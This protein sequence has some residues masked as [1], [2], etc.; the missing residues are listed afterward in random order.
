M[1]LE[2]HHYHHYPEID[3]MSQQL[4]RLIAE[5]AEMSTVTQGAIVLIKDIRQKLID[6]GTDQAKLDE[7]AS[8]LDAR[9]NDLA[10]ALAEGTVA[11]DEPAPVS[12]QG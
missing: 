3:H 6:A 1:K 5:V 11:S 9:G 2:I 8:E 4:D 7:L 10:A 12:D